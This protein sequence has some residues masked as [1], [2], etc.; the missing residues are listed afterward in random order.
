MAGKPW[1]ED[2]PAT[3]GARWT[4][5]R[6][7]KARELYES[8]LSLTEL[9][10]P[11]HSTSHRIAAAIRK[12]GGSLRRRGARTEKNYF[13]KGGRVVDVDGYVL[14][15]VLNHPHA[16]ASGYVREHRLVMEQVLGR[17]VRPHEVVHHVNGDKA[18]NRPE[19]LELFD[20][21]AKHLAHELKGRRPKWTEEGWA[22]ILANVQS[23]RKPVPTVPRSNTGDLELPSQSVQNQNS[24]APSDVGQIAQAA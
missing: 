15:K 16:T 3:N 7:Q 18:D 19:N 13:W 23:R 24:A 2:Q 11:M 6:C 20:T 21:N 10:E 17:Y 12:V 9:E 1:A 5:D 8:G 14:L 4:K 22:R